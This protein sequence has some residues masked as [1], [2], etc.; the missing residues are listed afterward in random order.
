MQIC[1]ENVSKELQ[2][3][4]VLRGINLVLQSGK[5]YG[6]HGVNG[7]GKTMLMRALCGL[8][9]PS[10]GR[11]LVDGKQLGK[12][13]DFPPSVGLLLENPSFLSSMTGRDNLYLL[14]QLRRLGWSQVDE[15]LQAVGLGVRD[16]R[17][18]RKY[19]LGM[20]QRLGIAAAVMGQPDL[21]LLDEPFNALDAQGT[22]L[23]HDLIRQ[24]KERGALVV[25]ACHIPEELES[26]AD[27]IVHIEQGEVTSVRRMRGAAG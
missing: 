19:S 6:L 15:A 14:A 10:E 7:S 25:L 3:A 9:Y 22:Q 23:V 16:R 24:Q 2:G 20:K 5:I 26:L 12:D 17:K 1:V 8:M 21:V 13:I 4:Q 11:V 18:Y 27:E